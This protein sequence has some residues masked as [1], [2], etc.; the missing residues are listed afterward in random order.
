MAYDADITACFTGH[1]TYDGNRNEEL[2]AAIRELYARGYRT[3]LCGMA[4]GFDL[5]AAE[6]ALSLRDELKGLQVVAVVPFEGM[7]LRFSESQ[8]ALFERVAHG[9]DEVITL[10][11]RY[12]A[13]VYALRNNYLVDNCTAVIAYFTGQKGGTAYTVRRAVKKLAYII[14]I[15]NN[16]QQ[17]LTF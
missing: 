16:P 14:N 9:A 2:K 4:V 13:S 15:Y 7:Q 10:A 1:R 11:T 3:F 17:K 12:S 6:V 5:A 8:R